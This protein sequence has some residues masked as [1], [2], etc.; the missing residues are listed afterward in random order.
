H[1]LG[2]RAQAHE[3][4]SLSAARI[5]PCLPF[6][7]AGSSVPRRARETHTTSRA[8]VASAGIQPAYG[9]TELSRDRQRPRSAAMAAAAAPASSSS[10]PGWDFTCNFEVDYGSEEHASIV[11][12][13]LAVDKEPD[14][15]RREMTVSG[16]KLLVRFE[17]VEARFLRASFSAFVDLMVLITKLVEE[18]GVSKEE[19]S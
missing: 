12:K 19:H 4:K 15:V 14:K 17:A 6:P 16:G 8:G 3:N 2:R 5:G 18:Y 13:T 10:S 11:Y 9:R 1:L 7:F